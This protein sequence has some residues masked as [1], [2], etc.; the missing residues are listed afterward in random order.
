MRDQ[1][2]KQPEI[3]QIELIRLFFGQMNLFYQGVKQDFNRNIRVFAENIAERDY[4][5][6][7]DLEIVVIFYQDKS[8]SFE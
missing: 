2:L 1:N 8:Q 5:K 3:K 4:Q 6:I 7:S